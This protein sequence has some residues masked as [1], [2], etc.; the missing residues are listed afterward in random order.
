MSSKPNPPFSANQ[1]LIKPVYGVNDYGEDIVIPIFGLDSL[2]TRASFT[3]STATQSRQLTENYG[4]LSLLVPIDPVDAFISTGDIAFLMHKGDNTAF[5]RQ[6]VWTPDMSAFVYK[7]SLNLCAVMNMSAFT[8]GGANIDSITILVQEE[9]GNGNLREVMNQT[10]APNTVFTALVAL[11]TSQ[12]FLLHA[13]VAR[14]FKV[15]SGNP[16]I[17]TISI[18][19]TITGVNTVQIGFLSAHTFTP[20]SIAMPS[21]WI[22][23]SVGFHIHASLDHPFPVFRDQ[24]ADQLLD[25]KG[26]NRKGETIG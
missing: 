4:S 24:N 14:P 22:P 15:N 18:N 12:M 5:S 6:Y 26:T 10:I 13:E 20:N 1:V 11:S 9:I 19:T 3:L 23:S 16:L 7:V 21:L 25:Y 17:I 8:N 2:T